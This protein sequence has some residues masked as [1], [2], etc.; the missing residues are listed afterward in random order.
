MDPRAPA[1]NRSRR[2]VA[3]ARTRRR[4]SPGRHSRRA[5]ALASASARRTWSGVRSMAGSALLHESQDLAVVAVREHVE[6]TVGTFVDAANARVQI[7]Q[8][9]L[10]GDDVVV[11]VEHE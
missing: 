10:L 6:R 4:T 7:F 3:R 5:E 11:A 1:A 9:P 2:S 8:Q